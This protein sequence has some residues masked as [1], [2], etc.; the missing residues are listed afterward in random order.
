MQ[1]DRAVFE[2]REEGEKMKYYAVKAGRAPGVYDNWAEC[3]AQVFKYPG[4]VFKSFED[5]AEA[6]A[7][8]LPAES[9]PI[10]KELPAAFIDGSFNRSAGLYAWGGY[11]CANGRYHVIQGTG[12]NPDYLPD[13]N[14]AGEAFGALAAMYAA[15]KL[16]LR[17][18]VLYYD[19]AGIEQWAAGNWKAKSKLSKHY[20]MHA[21]LM[22]DNFV[23]VHFVKVKGHT[24]I[25]GNETADILAKEAAGVKIR[26]KDVQALAEF[27]AKAQAA[28]IICNSI[29]IE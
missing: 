8:I 1:R 27:K 9:T 19:Y 22:L 15:Q 26:K 20:Q 3:R 12:N 29:K 2:G 18:I 4:A 25:E 5:P 16:R 24:G 10:N 14:I 21:G 28:P 13:R 23:K 7:F 17:E 6:Q 11:I